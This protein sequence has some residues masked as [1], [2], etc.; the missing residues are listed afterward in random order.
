MHEAIDAGLLE[1]R[2]DGRKVA[3]G[4]HV[5]PERRTVS[6]EALKAWIAKAFPASKPSFLFDEVERNTHSSINADSYRALKAAYDA[7]VHL[8]DQANARIRE[9]A[10]EKAELESELLGLRSI[11]E[12]MNAPGERS[13]TTYLNIIGSLVGLMLRKSPG[14]KPYSVFESQAAIISA[15]LGNYPDV[16]GIAARTLEDKFAEAKRSLAN[17]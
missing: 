6:R 7:K 17:S 2:R 13:E 1:Y 16:P 15:L 8:L 3:A 5:A 9:L 10:N 4:E 14:G 12:K 11:V